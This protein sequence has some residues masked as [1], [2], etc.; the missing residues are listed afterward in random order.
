MNSNHIISTQRTCPHLKPVLVLGL[1]AAGLV[2]PARAAGPTPQQKEEQRNALREDKVFRAVHKSLTDA[3]MTSSAAARRA[4]ALVQGLA[5]PAANAGGNTGKKTPK[6][7]T[8]ETK[9][10]PDASAGSAKVTPPKKEQPAAD[11]P[12]DAGTVEQKKTAVALAEFPGKDNKHVLSPWGFF[13]TGFTLANPY[14]VVTSTNSAGANLYDLE[15]AGS[16]ASAYIEFVYNNRWAFDSQPLS[17]HTV[18]CK[19]GEVREWVFWPASG[20]DFQGRFGYTYASGTKESASTI[21]GASEFNVEATLARH[22][23]RRATEHWRISVGPEVSLGMATDRG[24]L[25]IHPRGFAGL[26]AAVGFDNLF[27]N[28][29]EEKIRQAMFTIR[30]GGAALDIPALEGDTRRFE[31]RHLLPE[32]DL[33]WDALA[34]ETELFYPLGKSVYLTAGGRVYANAHPGQWNLYLGLSMG[35]DRLN[36][37]FGNGGGDKE[38]PT[39]A[40]APK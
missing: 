39:P 34:M 29:A 12:A 16:T 19:P 25:D 31:Q 33:K 17:T 3:G 37:L 36:A 7:E 8:P 40:T 10:Q 18:D 9:P 6:P 35:L 38:N 32:Y 21:A 2:L 24:A 20:W 5:E 27:V 13:H 14:T 28:G 22:L 30:V 11:E 15:P 4:L 26:G 23:A 1:V